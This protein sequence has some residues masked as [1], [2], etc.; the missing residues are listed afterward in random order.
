MPEKDD[1][2]LRANKKPRTGTANPLVPAAKAAS[3][4]K[5]AGAIRTEPVSASAINGPTI[6]TRGESTVRQVKKSKAQ[7]NPAVSSAA[8]CTLASNRDSDGRVLGPDQLGQLT[9]W[10]NHG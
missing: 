2:L 9:Q 5:P 3:A 4:K 8:D 1:S 10:R 6:P 7:P